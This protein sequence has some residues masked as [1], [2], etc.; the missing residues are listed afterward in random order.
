MTMMSVLVVLVGRTGMHFPI[1]LDLA[2][3][4]ILMNI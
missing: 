1:W 4:V 2:N 3:I